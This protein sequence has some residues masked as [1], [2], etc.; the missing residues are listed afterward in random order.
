MKTHFHPG[1]NHKIDNLIFTRV[2]TRFH[3]GEN[4]LIYKISWKNSYLHTMFWNWRT[5]TNLWA[6]AEN[7][8]TWPIWTI[9]NLIS[10]PS[11]VKS[12]GSHLHKFLHLRCTNQHYLCYQLFRSKTFGTSFSHL[13]NSDLLFYLKNLMPNF[14]NL[15]SWYRIF[16]IEKVGTNNLFLRS[17]KLIPHFSDRK[18]WCRIS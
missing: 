10:C 16:E 18:S 3:P 13:K 2:K 7:E 4:A 11:S 15:K 12:F 6:R 9:F 14:S 1:E 5:T 8:V 17:K